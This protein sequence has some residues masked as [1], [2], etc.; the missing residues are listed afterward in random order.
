MSDR[1]VHPIDVL[2]TGND[3]SGASTKENPCD[4][5][6]P[7]LF[8]SKP[9][10]VLQME[11]LDWYL[12]RQR[13]DW[14]A[15]SEQ[16]FTAW[17]F[18]GEAQQHFEAFVSCQSFAETLCR[19]PAEELARLRAQVAIDKAVSG[20][21][22]G[23]PAS[24]VPMAKGVLHSRIKK[25]RTS[26]VAAC[27]MLVIGMV[28]AI[29][30]H[31]YA[32]PVFQQS[33]A[34]AR[35]QLMAVDLPDGTRLDLD[36]ATRIDVAFYRKRREVF[37]K[38]GQV[39]FS[40][41]SDRNRPFRVDAGETR[42]TVLGTR[43]SVRGTVEPGGMAPVN[44]A[45]QSGSVRVEAR[46]EGLADWLPFPLGGGRFAVLT[47]G[48]QARALDGG[49]PGEVVPVSPDEI[50]SWRD[51]RLSFDNRPLGE[52]VAEL[53]RYV[54]TRLVVSDSALAGLRVTAT[55]DP[56]QAH[57]LKHLLPQA[58]PVQVVA[59]GDVLEVRAR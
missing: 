47:A 37:L 55:F 24:F 42:A 45:V 2:P 25:T 26:L 41:A 16:E 58:L 4:E 18:D 48:Q 51:L 14:T 34:T 10:T 1:F 19:L 32:S 12:S 44:V 23:V 31:D 13:D 28:A 11:A 56:R 27:V 33:Y 20:Q 30:H 43:F 39:M 36:T 35:G 52:V 22:C 9:L 59:K 21:Q 53:N 29:W 46:P 50:A 40:V 38:D 8:D 49:A 3:G 6:L 57:A 7:A 15:E 54:D 17:L 5:M